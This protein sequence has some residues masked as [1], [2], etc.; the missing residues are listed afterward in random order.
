MK[1]MKSHFKNNKNKNH[2]MVIRLV[3]LILISLF[4]GLN[5][6]FWNA[7][8]LVGNALPMP[9]GYG[10]AVVLSGSMEPEL[11]V[12]D[13]VFLHQIDDYKVGDI[14]V[15]QL[16][17][18]LIIHRIVDIDDETGEIIT[19]GDANNVADAPISKKNIKG[20]MIACIPW[21]GVIVEMLHTPIGIL[22]VL[23][24]ALVLLELSYQCEYTKK[25]KEIENIKKEIRKLRKE[26]ND[27][28]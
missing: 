3:F 19:Q 7:N 27:N 25:D 26:T 1:L 8:Q 21:V 10:G 23:V 6:Y 14:V 11:S 24:L 15:Y 22:I 12:N 2:K 20:K 18:E 9:F 5:I 28:E 4:L 13:L 17:N 16:E